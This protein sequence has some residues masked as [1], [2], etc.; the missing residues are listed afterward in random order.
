MAK[1]ANSKKDEFEVVQ[2]AL[3]SSEAFVEKNQ[4][5]LLVG[6]GIAVLVVLVVLSIRNFY[7]E[8]RKV[9]AE[10]EMYKAQ[11]YF[12][13]DSFRLALHG[14]EVEC[15]GFKSIASKYRM[16]PSGNLAS[17]Y[18]GIC[19]YKLGDFQNAIEY[20]SD[21]NGKDSYLTP[22]VVGL[23]GDCH[24]E[25]GDNAKAISY[26]EK[27]GSMKNNVVSPIYLKK[28]GL[29]YEADNQPQKAEK[30]YTEIKTSYPTS[31]EAS[32]IDKY[33]ARVAQ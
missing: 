16:T 2:E 3:G 15:L 19:Y 18:A 33:I 17:A 5:Q 1:K 6:V 28:A 14:D 23:M 9:S 30:C 4:K 32:D 20:L 27:A 13:A 25:L 29:L 21:F 26:F 22:T 8:P 31:Q 24:A 11:T 12:A 10:N 7:F